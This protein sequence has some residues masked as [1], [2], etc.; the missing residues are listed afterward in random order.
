MNGEAAGRSVSRGQKGQ[1]HSTW[2][3]A[4]QLMQGH[5]RPRLTGLWSEEDGLTQLTSALRIV[6]PGVPGAQLVPMP[7]DHSASVPG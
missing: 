7:S 4:Q 5:P 3:Q 2:Q 1:A 6:P